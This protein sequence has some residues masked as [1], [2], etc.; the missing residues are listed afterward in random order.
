MDAHHLNGV[1]IGKTASKSP[2]A[3][4]DTE[5]C[6]TASDTTE[7]MD[8]H[9]RDS[10]QGTRDKS[11][12]LQPESPAES[13]VAPLSD[14]GNT[15]ASKSDNVFPPSTNIQPTTPLQGTPNG[16]SPSQEEKSESESELEEQIFFFQ[17]HDH[18]QQQQRLLKEN[19]TDNS[20]VEKALS[21][22]DQG[23]AP[24]NRDTEP[25]SDNDAAEL[26]EG[27][28]FHEAE[29]EE[30]KYP[31]SDR[32][33]DGAGERPVRQKLKETSIAGVAR[34]DL[35]QDHVMASQ[36]AP[37]SGADNVS[38]TSSSDGRGRLRRKRSL[39]NVN[40]DDEDDDASGERG[41]DDVGHRRKRSRDSK[42][43]D[44]SEKH[45]S[46]ERKLAAAETQDMA[47]TNAMDS[48]ANEV[49]LRTPTEHLKSVGTDAVNKILSPKKK[50]GRDQFD[51]DLVKSDNV[52]ETA[53]EG[54]A[55]ASNG[56][57]V[58][59]FKGTSINRTVK[60]EPEKKRHRDDSQDR[61]SQVDSDLVPKK[62]TPPN[63]FSNISAVSPFASIQPSATSEQTPKDES[64]VK[65]PPIT[66]ASAFASSALAAFA[67]SERS[68]FGTL[69]ASAT[70][71]SPF[72]PASTV[73]PMAGKGTAAPSSSSFAASPFAAAAGASPFSAFGGGGAGFGKSAFASGFGA[74]APRLGG[75]LTSFA[76]P[77]G[78]SGTLESTAKQKIL[79]AASSD[80]EEGEEEGEG[81]DEGKPAFEGLEEEKGDERFHEQQTETGEEGED[82]IFSC[83]GKLFHFDGKEWKERGVGLFKVNVWEPA[84]RSSS[85]GDSKESEE[86]EEKAE[87]EGEGE[88]AA[89]A[90][91]HTTPKKKTARLLMRADG[92]WRVILNIPVFKGMKAGDPT[93]ARPSGKQVHFAG[94]EEGRS[95]PFLFRTGN[96]DVAKE[97]YVTIRE[98]Q[99][100]L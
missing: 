44:E 95:V 38:D 82:T 56:D 90:E 78:S 83:R 54:A 65:K 29:Q 77:A 48:P 96:D 99:E 84:T 70:S 72:K 42:A 71:T 73:E 5:P 4:I 14:S 60:G 66:S 21:N 88:R 32:P 37:V 87:A 1:L 61:S 75:G 62:I 19:S 40:R 13:D 20:N 43:E 80:D 63:P 22:P 92:V 28:K 68:P 45:E 97:L 91:D 17:S 67:G 46:S 74:A 34:A 69:G 35:P 6:S 3:S 9:P 31:V 23:P 98:L 76:A 89:A 41:V 52:D 39:E 93:G 2:S 49:G 59:K 51:T 85:D 16:P 30:I 25:T 86:D 94:F 64:K 7:P 27:T 10:F 53:E 15:E 36:T 57:P 11:P 18:Q 26:S 12:M 100:S 47:D 50:R 33:K 81:G 24:M 79:G 58:D 8:K 55:L